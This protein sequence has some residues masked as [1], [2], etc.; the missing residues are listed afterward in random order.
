MLVHAL[1][2]LYVMAGSDESNLA[3]VADTHRFDLTNRVWEDLTEEQAYSL[4]IIPGSA[5]FDGWL[6]LFF[7]WSTYDSQDI[8]RV[9]KAEIGQFP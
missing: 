3:T 8:L 2:F 9:Y 5:V 4:V 6:Y 7:G 1:G